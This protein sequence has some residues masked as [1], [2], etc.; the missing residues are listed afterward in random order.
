MT[1]R[2]D[3]SNRVVC[4]SVLRKILRN[5]Q[6][7]RPQTTRTSSS[8]RSWLRRASSANLSDEEIEEFVHP[9]R[10]ILG[11]TRRGQ[12]GQFDRTTAR[13]PSLYPCLGERVSEFERVI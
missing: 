7:Q 5:Y 8:T 4:S 6:W 13:S 3:A 9:F 1:G 12:Q 2:A 10:G 11:C